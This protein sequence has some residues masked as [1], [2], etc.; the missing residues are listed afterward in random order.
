MEKSVKDILSEMEEK[1]RKS[2]EVTRRELAAI[3]TGR[4][5]T[6]LLD[7]VKANYY[8]TLTP[9]NQ[10]ANI[11]TP[12]PTLIVIQ[13]WDRSTLE[14]IERAILKADIGLTPNNDGKV[15]RLPI[16]PLSQE[17]RQE[18]VRV[19]RKMVEEGRVAIRGVRHK[20][21][22]SVKALEKEGKISED[23]SRRAQEKMDE[24]THKY[25]EEVDKILASKEKEILEV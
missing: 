14:E 2:V 22:D 11:L 17:R 8:S 3:R 19:V 13:P 23:V 21:R 1:M 18:L 9:L 25:I 15:I 20:E 6:A 4:A 5:S 24:L 7:G 16:P 10:I 12:E